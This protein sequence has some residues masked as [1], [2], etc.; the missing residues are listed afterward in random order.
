MA[1]PQKAQQDCKTQK[2]QNKLTKSEDFEQ[3]EQYEWIDKFRAYGKNVSITSLECMHA[4]FPPTQMNRKPT[5]FFYKRDNGAIID[6]EQQTPSATPPRTL[7][8]Y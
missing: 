7:A 1:K 2:M 8:N 5:V 3:P 4:C 6:W